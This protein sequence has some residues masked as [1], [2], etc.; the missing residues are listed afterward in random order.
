MSTDRYISK[1]MWVKNGLI[2]N[3]D[4]RHD[5][6]YVELTLP[7]GTARAWFFDDV[8]GSYPSGNWC[9]WTDE[10]CVREAREL[11]GRI[12]W[13]NHDTSLEELADSF[14]DW[15]EWELGIEK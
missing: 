7:E 10:L 15:M 6:L 13:W 8:Y 3:K 9:L 2:P 4:G 14:V 5:Y 11:Y 1:I 12:S